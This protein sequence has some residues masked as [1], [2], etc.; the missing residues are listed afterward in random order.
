MSFSRKPIKVLLVLLLVAL[1][2]ACSQ[3]VKKDVLR[4]L[5]QQVN[6][7]QS[8]LIELRA[9]QPVSAARSTNMMQLAAQ[10][11]SSVV[12]ISSDLNFA[13]KTAAGFLYNSKG[14]ILTT[15]HVVR[16]DVRAKKGEGIET[17][18]AEYVNIEFADGR[19]T[20]GHVLGIDPKTD[21]AAIKVDLDDL[22]APVS[23]ASRQV[24]QGE[25]AFTLGHPLGLLY[26][27]QWRPISA[28]YR[29]DK[30]FDSTVHQLDGGFLEGDS[31]GPLFDLEG[32][33]IGM[34]Y[35][36]INYKYKDDLHTDKTVVYSAV[37]WAIPVET[38]V[39]TA[40]KLIAGDYKITEWK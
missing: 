22:P 9:T 38:I 18:Y 24:Q 20:R 12:I 7:L 16:V 19:K 31:G 6:R 26:T 17:Y 1:L 39:E 3:T 30:L 25:Q 23:I 13:Y 5:Q 27:Q 14:I 15:D 10:V 32:K 36:S 28:A 29:K 35:S 37:G 40:I 11:K 21:L 4:D 2:N 33:L 34:A 8:E